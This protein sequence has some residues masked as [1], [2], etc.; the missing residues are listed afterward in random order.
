MP[1]T[2]ATENRPLVLIATDPVGKAE[3]IRGLVSDGD[4]AAPAIETDRNVIVAVWPAR[5]LEQ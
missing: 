4:V 3:W 1:K 2:K 5:V